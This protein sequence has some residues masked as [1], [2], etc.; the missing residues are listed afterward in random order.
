MQHLVRDGVRLG[1]ETAGEGEPAM[2]FVHGWT[3]DHTFFAPQ[4]EYFSARRRVIAVDLRGHG[5]SDAPAGPYT[6]PGFADDLAWLCGQLGVDNLVVVGHSMGG[7][8][9]M[10]LAS[11]YPALVRAAVLVDAPVLLTPEALKVRVELGA[12]LAAPDGPALARRYA[13]EMFLPTD[14]AIRRELL[15]ERM[16]R[17]P[18]HVVSGCMLG[19]GSFDMLSAAQHISQPVLYIGAD[20]P[21]GDATLLQPHLPHIVIEQTPGVGHFNQLEAADKVTGIIERFLADTL[22]I[23]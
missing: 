13:Y 6:M 1:Y 3:C 5:E 20:K 18:Q 17:T 12:A 9:S 22:L 7:A 11:A 4:F 15:V 2:L 16:M 10:A 8:V 21:R 14:D 23:S 19:I